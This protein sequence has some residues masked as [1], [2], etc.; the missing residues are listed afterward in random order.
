M[1]LFFASLLLLICGKLDLIIFVLTKDALTALLSALTGL[2]SAIFSAAAL[3]MAFI[4]MIKEVGESA[5]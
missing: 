2:L 1:Q 4:G 3:I 5:D